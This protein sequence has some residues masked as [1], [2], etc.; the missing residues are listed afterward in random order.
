MDNIHSPSVPSGPVAGRN[1]FKTADQNKLSLMDLMAEKQRVESELSA[2]SGVL[3][4][5]RTDCV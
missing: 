2:L 3:D 5:V 4:T 1:L